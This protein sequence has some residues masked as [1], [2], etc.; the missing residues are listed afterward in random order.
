[1]K[2]ILFATVFC[3]SVT[4]FAQAQQKASIQ[5]TAD[6]DTVALNEYFS[7]TV[8]TQNCD[9]NSFR[10]PETIDE[11]FTLAGRPM[12]QSSMS[13][14]NGKMSSSASY[15]YQLVPKKA[16]KIEIENIEIKTTDG[17]TIKA[18]KIKIVVV[19]AAKEDNSGSAKNKTK[20]KIKNV[21]P[22]LPSPFDN[23][24]DQNDPFSRKPKRKTI[25]I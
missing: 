4:T 2:K 17:K 7:L 3:A 14:V 9:M 22:A 18:E 13:Y 5:A 11:N 10:M 25:Q 15:T 19:K 24:N 6:R 16:G 12:T 21:P 23:P 20:P 8:M 1:M